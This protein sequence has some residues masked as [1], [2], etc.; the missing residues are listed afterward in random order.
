[1]KNAIKLLSK[2]IDLANLRKIKFQLYENNI[3]P[4]LRFI[5]KQNLE[6]SGWI[7][8]NNFAKY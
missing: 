2:P 3:E 8:I 4:Y 1:M 7:E 5:H 6:V